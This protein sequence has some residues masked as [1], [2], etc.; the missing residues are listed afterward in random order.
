MYKM[1]SIEGLLDFIRG[2]ELVDKPIYDTHYEGS[3]ITRCLGGYCHDMSDAGE[4]L[5]NE[6]NYLVHFNRQVV[7]QI[8]TAS[9]AACSNNIAE[10]RAWCELWSIFIPEM[11]S[12]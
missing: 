5:K 2:G 6:V 12:K 8:V 4:L 1:F 11:N 3:S 7:V 9:N 10:D